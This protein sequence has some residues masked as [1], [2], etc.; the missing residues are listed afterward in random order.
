MFLFSIDRFRSFCD[1][2]F[3]RIFFETIDMKPEN[4][5]YYFEIGANL[6]WAI[7][8]TALFGGLIKIFIEFNG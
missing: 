4:K 3:D 2:G 6:F 5:E 8:L 7:I 1:R